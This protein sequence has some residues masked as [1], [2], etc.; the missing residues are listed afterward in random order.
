MPSTIASSATN[1]AWGGW[2]GRAR[3]RVEFHLSHGE[4]IRT[5]SRHG[6]Q[7]LNLV[8]L[9]APEDGDPGWFDWLTLEWSRRWPSEEIWVAAKV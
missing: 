5:L 9:Q 3:A 8:E 6:F 2:S 4:M 1:S 7:V